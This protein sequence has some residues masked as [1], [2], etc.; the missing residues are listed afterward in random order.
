MPAKLK[1]ICYI[2]RNRL[3]F[4]QAGM[5]SV[6]TI[7]LPETVVQNMEI[8][9][10]DELYKTIA[11]F[12]EANKIGLT[13]LICIIATNSMFEKNIETTPPQTPDDQITAFL[14]LVPFDAITSKVILL[15]KGVKVIAV[16]TDFLIAIKK[17]FEKVGFAIEA[18]VTSVEVNPQAYTVQSLDIQEAARLIAMYEKLKPMTLML[19]EKPSLSA[20][21]KKNEVENKNKPSKLF[22]LLVVFLFIGVGVLIF[23]VFKK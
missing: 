14:D 15:D 6:L 18:Y 20:P 23:L 3:D 9:N 1:G 21:I 19:Q 11:S 17:A 4:Y 22:P 8:V 5:Q 13:S 10:E 2:D 16:N 12:V 7:A